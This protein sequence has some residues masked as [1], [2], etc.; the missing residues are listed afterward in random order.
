MVNGTVSSLIVDNSDGSSLSSTCTP[1]PEDL[2]GVQLSQLNISRKACVDLR[3]AQQN[4]DVRAICMDLDASSKVTGDNVVIDTSN[5]TVRGQITGT[6]ALWLHNAQAGAG[7]VEAHSGSS[8]TCS[9]CALK[10]S[11]A[12]SD[13]TL[14]GTMSGS[15][16]EIQGLQK[17][18]HTGILTASGSQLT[19]AAET[20]SFSGIV[21]CTGS[22][23]SSLVSV[24]HTLNLGGNLQCT[25]GKCTLSMRSGGDITSTATISCSGN[26]QCLVDVASDSS[27]SF[28]GSIA[29][30]DIRMVIAESLRLQGTVSS[31]GQGFAEV[32]GDGKGNR[33][34]WSS[35]SYN[36]YFRVSGSGGGHGGNG[37]AACY[38][39]S[40]S[41]VLP[42]GN[43]ACSRSFTQT[44][45]HL[46]THTIKHR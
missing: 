15:T 5:A 40:T 19:I 21:R 29:A 14:G 25:N 28:G 16:V 17:L 30:S 41:W 11:L 33:P 38:R 2:S 13:V 12:G 24:N 4:N 1:F 32:S 39:Y 20:A 43:H 7:V 37:A 22:A 36:D 26:N 6:S 3:L 9:S 10:M 35:T 34:A 27:A 42:A 31:N 46:H 45:T 18:D 23:C 8:M 44:H